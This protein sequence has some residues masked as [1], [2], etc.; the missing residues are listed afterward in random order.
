MEPER[1]RDLLAD[2]HGRIQ[3]GH[4]VLQDHRDPRAAELAHLLG[5]L[6]E[7]ALAVEDDVAPDDLAAGLGHQSQD[8]QAGHRLAGARFADDPECLAALDGER[9]AVDRFHD[10]AARIDVGPEIPDLE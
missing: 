8:R 2:R 6:G 3:R 4:R 5:A 10:T 1:L 7:Q 9:R